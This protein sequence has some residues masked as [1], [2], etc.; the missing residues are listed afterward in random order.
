MRKTSIVLFA[1]ALGVSGLITVSGI[2][3]PALA[4]THSLKHTD[5]LKYYSVIALG[6]A[7]VDSLGPFRVPLVILEPKDTSRY[8]LRLRFHHLG[9]LGILDD[10]ITSPSTIAKQGQTIYRANHP[11]LQVHFPEMIYECS[12]DVFDKKSGRLVDSRLRPYSMKLQ[13]Y[14]N[15]QYSIEHRPTTGLG[16]EY[17]RRT[18]KP[19]LLPLTLTVNP[20]WRSKETVDSSGV[21][22][23]QFID[24]VDSTVLFMSLSVTPTDDREK[25]DSSSWESFK[26]QARVA[27]GAKDVRINSLSDFDV[28]DTASRNI[29][30]KGYE[31]L[32]KDPLK[33]I[34][35]VATFRTPRAIILILAP[36]GNVVTAEK[37]AYYRAISRSLKLDSPK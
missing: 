19:T 22:A 25:F 17:L 3:F 20:G 7:T 30:Q 2:S 37:L 11:L 27:F 35:Y 32:T 18:F 10:T 6:S 29:V 28:D 23:L 16:S 21:Y 34:S 9:M 14:K 15:A 33:D 8:R 5:S 13:R 12:I 26:E 1:L 31:F 36:C 4:Q 24:P